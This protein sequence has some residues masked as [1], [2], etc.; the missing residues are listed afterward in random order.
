MHSDQEEKWIDR[1]ISWADINTGTK[2]RDGINHF[3][4]RLKKDFSSLDGRVEELILPSYITWEKGELISKEPGNALK[5]TKRQDS[6]KKI[7]F[8]GHL[9]TV[10]ENDS[11]FKHAIRLNNRLI[12]PGVADMKGG[13]L[14]LLKALEIFESLPAASQIGWTILL[15]PDE[16]IGSPSSYSLL[17]EEAKKHDWGLVFE[18][19][20]SDGAIVSARKGS[21]NAI[22][23]SKGKKA[24]AGRDFF[25]GVNAFDPL[26]AF[27]ERASKISSE[28]KGVSLNIA[29]LEGGGPF[30]IVP[31]K[32]SLSFNF[33]ALSPE[34]FEKGK[35]ELKKLYL[36][37]QNEFA[38]RLSWH[39][40]AERPPK[41]F[42]DK[43]QKLYEKLETAAK[44][45]SLPLFF[46]TSGGVS[47]GN[48]FSMAGLATIDTLGVKGKNL[49][50]HEEEA[51]IDSL[52]EK[53]TLTVELIKELA[54]SDV[55]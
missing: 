45:L 41:P 8:S 46:R 1:W 23:Q 7:L 19:A 5:I 27:A 13:L 32:A 54:I 47:D 43:H 34:E 39:T 9:D 35:Q 36:R 42:D 30:N 55:S 2:N 12:G 11:S 49:H 25:I 15:T 24:H 28:T 33:R 20:Y 17:V 52:F 40:L 51:D 6:K 18:P 26:I 44:K 22:I 29:S 38:S 16:E 31:D 21:L 3:I 50:T 10:F 4:Q 14:V 53:A 37:L 48:L